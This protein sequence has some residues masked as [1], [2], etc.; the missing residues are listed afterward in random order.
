LG[1]YSEDEAQELTNYFGYDQSLELVYMDD[2]AYDDWKLLLQSQIDA[3]QPMY[4]HGFGSGGH[5]FNVDGYQDTMFFHFNWGW[6]GSYNGYFHLFNLNPGG[7]TFSYGQG[8]IINFIPAGNNG[9]VPMFSTIGSIPP[10]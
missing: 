10:V 1:A 9:I 7:N 6:G 4:Y 5:A 2:Y 3:G 8:V